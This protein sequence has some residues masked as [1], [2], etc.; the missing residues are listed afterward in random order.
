MIK[1]A[2]LCKKNLATM[3]LP[4]I[5]LVL[6]REKKQS[7]CIVVIHFPFNNNEYSPGSKNQRGLRLTTTSLKP[8]YKDL[9]HGNL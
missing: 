2:P 8:N 9:Y 5:F 7:I 3:I 4:G 1:Y 6:L